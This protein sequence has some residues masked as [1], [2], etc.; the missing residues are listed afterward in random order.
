MLKWLDPRRE[1]VAYLMAFIAI[2][3]GVIQFRNGGVGL[4]TVLES[5]GLAILGWI[6]R[7]SVMP[8]KNLP[9]AAEDHMVEEGL[10]DVSQDPDWWDDE[11]V[12]DEADS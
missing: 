11:E 10:E 7:G 3:N 4:T 6:T 2:V 12:L 1:P 5:V 8:T 9:E